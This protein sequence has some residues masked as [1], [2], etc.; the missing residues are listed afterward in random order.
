M[1]MEK[2]MNRAQQKLTTREKLFDSAI[3]LFNKQGIK[4]TKIIDIAKYANVSTGTFY[5][6]FK[7]KEE[8]ISSIYYE[9]FNRFM[10]NKMKEINQNELNLKSYLLKIG[11]L[12]LE[13]ADKVGVEVTTVAFESNLK[14]NMTIIGNHS[15][16]RYFSHEIQNTIDRSTS[17]DNEHKTVV[18]K[19]FETIIRGI[20]MTWCFNNG[21]ENIVAFGTALL[22][23][24][25]T[26]IN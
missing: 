26:G 17:L 18:F 13:F 11:I 5:V 21:N 7:S 8:I 20:M 19:E 24:Y 15:K 4:Q 3:I 1:S 14:T 12:E 2:K 16:K 10:F 22:S 6:H 9:E 23:R 25:L